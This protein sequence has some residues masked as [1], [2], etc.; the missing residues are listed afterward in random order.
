MR[1]RLERSIQHT[2][3]APSKHESDGEKAMES[4]LLIMQNTRSNKGA[5]N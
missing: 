1:T 5:F 2:S 3:N 4:S